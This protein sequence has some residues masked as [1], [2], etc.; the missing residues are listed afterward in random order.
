V[1]RLATKTTDDDEV[2]LEVIIVG[3]GPDEKAL[4]AADVEYGEVL[5]SNY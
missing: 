2:A 5:A 1:G 3:T 4:T